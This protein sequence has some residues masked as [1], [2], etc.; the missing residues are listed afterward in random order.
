MVVGDVGTEEINAE[1]SAGSVTQS[2][3]LLSAARTGHREEEIMKS[4]GG[5]YAIEDNWETLQK[6]GSTPSG[7]VKARI[8]GECML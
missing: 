6:C 8:T 4:V 2:P 5:A 7:F 1:R 3:E